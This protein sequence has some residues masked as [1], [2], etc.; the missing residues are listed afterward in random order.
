VEEKASLMKRLGRKEL[1]VEL[2]EPVASIPAALQDRSLRLEED[3]RVLVYDYDTAA[4]RTGLAH[5]MS[6]LSAAGLR[7]RDVDTRKSTLEDI[8]VG[9]VHKQEENAA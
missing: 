2:D 8:F 4:E 1:R 5:L 6:E 3:G 7:V 9:L